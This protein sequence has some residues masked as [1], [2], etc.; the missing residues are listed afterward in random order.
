MND[1]D[2]ESRARF[3]RGRNLEGVLK[4]NGDWGSVDGEWSG[5]D[6]RTETSITKGGT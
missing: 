6:I 1:I 2:F 3:R 5:D 4:D